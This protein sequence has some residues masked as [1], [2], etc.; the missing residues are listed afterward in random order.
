MFAVA[1]H[2]RSQ[3]RFVINLKLR[4]ENT[5]KMASPI[6]DMKGTCTRVASNKVRSKVDMKAAYEQVRLDPDSV[7]NSGFITP[8][9][10]FVSLAL[11]AGS[12]T[13]P[14]LPSPPST[15]SSTTT[16]SFRQTPT[17]HTFDTSKFV[18]ATLSH[19]KFYLSLSKVDFMADELEVLGAVISNS[20]IHVSP[21]KWDAV[22]EWPTPRSAKD[23][24]RFMGTIQWMADHLPRLSEIAALLT[25]LTGKV[26]FE[27][28]PACK[29]AFSLL[30]SLVPETLIP[31]SFEKVLAGTERLFLFTDASIFGC[32]GWLGQ[33]PTQDT[34]R[35]FRHF[36]SKWNPAQR[37][38]T[39][40]EQELL[41][42][43]VGCLK[44]HEHL[45]GYHFTVVCN[46][47]PLK[48]YL[49]QPPKE[50]RRH[51]CLWES[52]KLDGTSGLDIP[53]APEPSPSHDDDA[54][55]PSKPTFCPPVILSSLVAALER[56][57]LPVLAPVVVP[58]VPSIVSALPDTFA[59]GLRA[60][61]LGAKVLDTPATHPGFLVNDGVVYYD[62]GLG[63]RL[64]VPQ[65]RF[66]LDGRDTTFVEA[67]VARLHELVGH[68]GAAKTLAYA[69]CFFWW[70]TMHTDVFKFCHLC[71]PCA[72]NKP[73]TS[74][75]FGLLH[76][77]NPQSRCWSRVGMDFVVGLPLN[78]HLNLPVDSILTVTD[79]LSKMVVL[80]PVMLTATAQEIAD[81]FY[82]GVF[83]RFGLPG[84]IVSDRDPKFHLL[85]LANL[86]ACE[87]AINSATSSATGLA[88]FETV[89]GFLPTI[90]LTGAWDSLGNMSAK[91]SAECARLSALQATDALLASRIEMTHYKDC[92][93][94]ASKFIPRFIGPYPVIAPDPSTSTY[95]L[96]LPPHLRIHPRFHA[97]KLRRHLPNND[98]IFP[99][100]AFDTPPAVGDV[101]DDADQEYLIEKIVDDKTT[102]RKREFKVRYLE[103]SAAEDLCR[104]EAELRATAKDTLEAYLALKKARDA[105]KKAKSA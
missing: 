40:T 81:I 30:K 34:A 103:Y 10:T 72:R 13:V 104:P 7:A 4:N 58:A 91:G 63:P 17:S 88:P 82:H 24:L 23:V 61:T 3:A 69:R 55:L 100:R 50:E 84:A 64:L 1:K 18:F 70:K 54:P 6:P 47:E 74:A 49:W 39:T 20:G 44:M 73:S 9:G 15:T 16:L 98:S 87:F 35:P 45:T 11:R 43:F 59:S 71:K 37:N 28:S 33:G 27:W 105:V 5:V 77:L 92:C 46:H 8:S 52:L 32:G 75:P 53:L 78:L 66:S 97:S 95:T 90:W 89:Y 19:Y 102:R 2:D 101:V 93:R 94:V 99:H 25:R 57:D 29:V 51:V 56:V 26:T 80:L 76:A 22:R 38:Y 67:V 14:Y 60:D 85:V 79:Y 12:T 21:E 83:K 68:L 65:G 42:V 36:L 96:A 86:V 31:L 62:N 41:G 48:T